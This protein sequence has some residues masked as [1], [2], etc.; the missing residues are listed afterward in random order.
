MMFPI[1]TES[2]YIGYQAILSFL[3][4]F[5]GVAARPFFGVD[6]MVAWWLPMLVLLPAVFHR[7]LRRTRW[8]VAAL[9]G[10][11]TVVNLVVAID[12]YPHADVSAG[13]QPDF[14]GPG[15][16]LPALLTTVAYGVA[17]AALVLGSRDRGGR[18]GERS[19]SKMPRSR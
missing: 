3:G 13:S 9:L 4:L 17:A 7:H 11:M 10:V 1:A 6:A 8:V 16:F 19:T 15:D 2:G 14:S 18:A 12:E 5:I